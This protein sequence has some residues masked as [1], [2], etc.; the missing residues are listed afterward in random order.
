MITLESTKIAFATW[1]AKRANSA[2]PIPAKLWKM[3]DSLL[4]TQKPFMICKPLGLS[5]SQSR[6]HCSN[7]PSAINK[8]RRNKK[9][10][11][12]PQALKTS[13]TNDFVTAVPLPVAKSPIEKSTSELI[14]K[15]SSKSL[16]LFIPTAALRDVLSVLGE[17]L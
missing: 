7:F 16:H 5:W 9:I 2:E 14:L 3:V 6:K 1:R 4:L 11:T 10:T 15:G 12:R 8:Q 13:P 17:L